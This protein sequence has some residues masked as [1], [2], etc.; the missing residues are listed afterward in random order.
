MTLK[1]KINKINVM[2]KRNKRREQLILIHGGVCDIV[3][4]YNNLG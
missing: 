4:S 3:D 2:H 1:V